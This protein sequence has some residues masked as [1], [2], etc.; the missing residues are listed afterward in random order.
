MEPH[1]QLVQEELEQH[2]VLMEPQHK[3]LV[4]EVVE[5]MDLHLKQVVQQPV[6]VELEEKDVDLVIQQEQ[7]ILVVEL[8]LVELVE[9]QV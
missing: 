1:L 2:Q 3:E 6:V 8:E 4:A 5:L 7:L 9:P